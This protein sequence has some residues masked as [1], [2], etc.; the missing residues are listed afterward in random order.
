MG[1]GSKTDI[2]RCRTLVAVAMGAAGRLEPAYL[3]DG[4]EYS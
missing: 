1:S 4:S 3:K 2:V